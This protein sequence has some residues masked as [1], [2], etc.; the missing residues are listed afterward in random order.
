V[1]AAD[2]L[3]TLQSA[4]LFSPWLSQSF[5]LEETASVYQEGT[6]EADLAVQH[7]PSAGLPAPEDRSSDWA[8]FLRPRETDMPDDG[9]VEHRTASPTASTTADPRMQPELELELELEALKVDDLI[10]GDALLS[11]TPEAFAGMRH[12]DL[13][14]RR[15]LSS[16]KK[17]KEV[18]PQ[19]PWDVL[20][21]EVDIL[22]GERVYVP[23]KTQ[24]EEQAAEGWVD[25]E[26]SELLQPDGMNTT[27]EDVDDP[28]GISAL[29][30]M[31]WFE[32]GPGTEDQ[33]DI[34]LQ[35][36]A[37]ASQRT[38]EG[39]PLSVPMP[40]SAFPPPPPRCVVGSACAVVFDAGAHA[41]LQLADFRMLVH[42][43]GQAHSAGASR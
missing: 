28:F 43:D 9:D 6:L 34:S 40:P 17:K 39:P 29:P 16:K 5:V 35:L 4:V 31:L 3:P 19:L 13:P 27:V 12:L 22:P 14:A 18:T 37:E 26:L 10:A 2:T 32:G 25:G 7:Q 36:N 24:A 21:T 23:K 41:R 1:H 30:Q 42:L 33:F 20:E 11:P 8:G 38:P 15:L